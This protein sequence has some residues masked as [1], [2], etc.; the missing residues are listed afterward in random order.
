MPH[1]KATYLFIALNEL[2]MLVLHSIATRATY[3]EFSEVLKN[4]Y[5]DHHLEAAFNSEQKRRAQ[6]V[7]EPLQEFATTIKH[8]AHYTCVELPKHQIS[9]E[10]DHEFDNGIR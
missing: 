6:L 9:K 5:G 2:I 7:G 3:K 4:H 10:A 8:L 1:E